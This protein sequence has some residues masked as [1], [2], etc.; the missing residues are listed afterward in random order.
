MLKKSYVS[1]ILALFFSQYALAFNSLQETG[2]LLKESEKQLLPELQFVTSGNT[3][4]NLIGR[5]D[6]GYDAD[7]NLRFLVG[8]G[9]TD[10]E[11][12]AY[13]KWV[14]YPDYD[15][16]PAVGFSFGFE[17]ARYKKENIAT[18]KN[19]IGIRAAPFVSKKFETEKGLFTPYGSLSLGF[20][21]YD[22][23]R[24]TPVQLILGSRYK[25]PEFDTCD[26]SAELG[27]NLSDADAY[28]SV[29]A[30]FPAFE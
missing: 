25:H 19:D 10:V 1:L 11:L 2:D 4:V 12:G 14:P 23:D 7:S 6:M 30:I 24:Y 21:S 13:Y 18:P 9:A 26:F 16:Q 27:F 3:G 29:A 20:N 28:F 17:Y 5:F 8:T 15:K 22:S